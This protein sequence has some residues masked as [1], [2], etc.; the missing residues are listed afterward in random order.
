[1]ALG[2]NGARD[3]DRFSV[4]K[5]QVEI[6]N[7]QLAHRQFTARAAS[8]RHTNTA[9]S[10]LPDA[11]RLRLRP[12][13]SLGS[14]FAKQRSPCA[15]GPDPQAARDRSR[16]AADPPSQL[17]R[18]CRSATAPSPSGLVA[19]PERRT[20]GAGRAQEGVVDADGVVVLVDL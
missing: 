20:D 2:L 17:G 3:V 11:G 7:N 8:E 1:S 13:R 16:A 9:V 4:A 10:R 19:Q 6:L 12:L 18:P 15:G 14:M 5:R